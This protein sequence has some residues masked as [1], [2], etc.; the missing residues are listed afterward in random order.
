[1]LGLVVL[2]GVAGIGFVLGNRVL[3]GRDVVAV[4]NGQPIAQQELA[5]EH[6]LFVT[7]STLTQGQPPAQLPTEFDILNQMIGDRLKFQA[8]ARAGITVSP[9]EIEAQIS[10]IEA[11]AGFTEAQLQAA[12]AQAGL[13]RGFLAD[14]IERQI[15]IG[16]YINRVVL[17][18]VPPQAQEAAVRAW[19]NSLQTQADVEIRLGTA[20]TRRAARVGEPAPDFALPTPGGETVRLSE[21]KGRPVLLNFWATWCPPCKIEMPDI[22]AL[23]QKYR[24]QGLT[25]IAVNQKESPAV[26]QA[27][28]DQMGLLF[29]PV[30]DSTGETF[31]IYRVVALPTSYFIDAQGIVRVHHRGMMTRE[32]MEGYVSQVISN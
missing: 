31:N 13:E 14:W 28:F 25:V 17:Q 1:M 10:Q 20:G 15:A 6:T 26:V 5:R 18:N 3:S 19:S 4:I 30:I 32:Q 27:Y 2:I 12:L 22:E 29:Q 16:Q 8:A 11:Q 24:A 23:Y 7:M 21:L 9:A